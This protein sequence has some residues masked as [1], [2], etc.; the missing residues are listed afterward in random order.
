VDEWEFQLLEHNQNMPSSATFI[1]QVHQGNIITCSD[2]SAT[3]SGGSYGYIISTKNGQRIAKGRGPA[4]GAQ[5]NSFRSE[6]YGVLATMRWLTHALRNN[7]PTTQKI[8]H[9]LD[10]RSVISR[11]KA[12]VTET[13]TKP[14]NTLQPDHD[15][16]TEIAHTLRSL[17]ITIEFEWVKGHQDSIKPY[18][19]LNLQAQL[20][21]DADHEASQYLWPEPSAA[22]CVPTLPHTPCQLILQGKTITGHNQRPSHPKKPSDVF[23]EE[24]WVG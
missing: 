19:Q 17:P 4:P 12:A 24:I 8:Y 11:I 7:P 10:N 21:C 23:D 14:N 5:L 22:S 3:D 18:H 20:N 6:A 13:Y 15:V 1:N 16:I 9:Y 2:G